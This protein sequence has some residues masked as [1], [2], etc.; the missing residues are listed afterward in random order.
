MVQDVPLVDEGGEEGYGGRYDEGFEDGYGE[1]YEEGCDEGYEVGFDEGYEAE[2]EAWYEA[3]YRDVWG[4][5]GEGEIACRN[6]G[7][8]EGHAADGQGGADDGDGEWETCDDGEGAV[9]A[10]EA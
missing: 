6:A 1:G 8:V 4:D 10:D 2:Y 5:E 3:G 9:T 7:E